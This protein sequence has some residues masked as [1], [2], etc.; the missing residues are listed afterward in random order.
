[1]IP[2]PAVL[3]SVLLSLSLH[4]QRRE[5]VEPEN[6]RELSFVGGTLYHHYGGI[7]AGF[8][9]SS[10]NRGRPA[11]F[12]LSLG[13]QYHFRESPDMAFKFSFWITGI[14]KVLAFSIT[15]LYYTDFNRRAIVFRPEAG[16]AYKRLRLLYGY[17]V[18]DFTRWVRP[19]YPVYRHSV[20]LTYVLQMKELAPSAKQMRRPK[21]IR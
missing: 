18:P 13:S 15:E 14:Y 6:I 3:L 17:N 7:E 20:S 16:L 2:R 4:A 19:N 9:Y 21:R 1:M 5:K 12:G 11:G 10:W 8:S